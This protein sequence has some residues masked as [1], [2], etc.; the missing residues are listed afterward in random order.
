M[1]KLTVLLALVLVVAA[2]L[3]GIQTGRKNTLEQEKTAAQTELGTVKTELDSVKAELGTVK[4]ELDTAKADLETGRTEL[5]SVTAE[6]GTAREQITALGTQ[7]D[8]AAS[9]LTALQ[10]AHDLLLKEKEGLAEQVTQANN[11]VTAMTDERVT[12]AAQV[13]Q[14][15]QQLAALTAEKTALTGQLVEAQAQIATLTEGQ[16]AIE[17]ALEGVDGASGQDVAAKISQLMT[18]KAAL[19]TELA[20]LKA[21]Q[22]AVE[23]KLN[24]VTAE[25]ADTT[26][27]K[28][29]AEEKL[30][31]LTTDKAAADEALMKANTDKAAVDAALSQALTKAEEDKA[32]AEAALLKANTDKAAVDDALAKAE[33]GKTTAEDELARLKAD[34]A[35]AD[36]ALTKAEQDKAA[37]EAALA[38]AMADKAAVEEALSRTEAD[39]TAAQSD[40]AKLTTDKAAVEEALA[41]AEQDKAAAE[42][43]LAQAM[44]DKAA[45]ET[46]LKAAQDQL[47]AFLP[48]KGN[49]VVFHTNDV[50]ARVTGNDKDQI[51]YARMAAVVEA[52]RNEDEVL[53]LDAG[54]ALHGM[55]F[56]GAARGQSVVDLMNLIGYDA[57]TPGN[58]DFNYGYE[59]LKELEKGMSFPLVNANILLAD[60]SH[61]FTPYVV[62]EISG[63]RVAIV[64]AANPQIQTAIHPARIEGL[65]FA[66]IEKIEEAVQAARA[67]ADVVIV[68]AHWGA[69]D[70]YSP[71]S[72][73]LA[74]IPGVSLVVDGHSHT[75]YADIRQQ[76]GAALVVSAGE[77]LTSLGRATLRFDQDDRLTIQEVPVTFEEAGQA[78]RDERIVKAIEDITEAQSV[79]LSEVLGQAA[80][81]LEGERA[82]VRTRETNLGDLAADA[83]LQ[84]TG[85]D[86]AFT[87]GGGIRRSV[88]AGDITRNDVVE[89]FPFG[90]SLVV[91]EVTG[92]QLV[93]A[94]EHGLRLYP[95][96]N[97][98]FPQVAGMKLAFDP[99]A[100]PGRR[101]T[102]LSVGDVP[103]ESGKTYRLATNDFLAA[104]GDGYEM[105]KACPVITY[106]GTMDEVLGEHIMQLG[107]VAGETGE[108]IVIAE[109]PMPAEEEKPAADPAEATEAPAATEAPKAA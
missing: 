31:Q 63:R 101:V 109:P 107:T 21:D 48:P 53:L 40:L 100:E 81:P 54:D 13:E 72:S 9:D 46:E 45:L 33:A 104:G 68:L 79:L 7:R 23:E 38:Q 59:R 96:Q 75:Q 18:D 67:E 93:Q 56:A 83:F 103:V 86:V 14:G 99:A 84:A 26:A 76:E 24:Q 91:I 70:A 108:R 80:V 62:K 30:A 74:A 35:S 19:E 36:E 42:A 44:T 47:Q 87:N 37:A 11:V 39:K 60:G 29:A 69:S 25:L 43:A 95:E 15:N 8:Q 90:N 51:G 49:V 34:K 5:D 22:A 66:G 6:L 27:A 71:N 94:M 58:H 55:A 57:M 61:A 16:K 82:D 98:G 4:T 52:A 102:A 77:Y 17:A 105:L 32:A 20:T 106:L 1:K 2:V 10:G 12:L 85:A 3:I 89:V 64:G 73:V 65:T 50:H 92:E 78:V 88:P 28:A 41:K 97:G